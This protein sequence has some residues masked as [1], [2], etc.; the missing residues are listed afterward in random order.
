MHLLTA[1]TGR[2]LA[3]VRRSSEYSVCVEGAL[4]ATFDAGT[5]I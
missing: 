2:D 1:H 4:K 3:P 5:K